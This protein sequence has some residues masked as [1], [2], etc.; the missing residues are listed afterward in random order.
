MLLAAIGFGLRRRRRLEE[1]DDAFQREELPP[2]LEEIS[3][4]LVQTAVSEPRRVWTQLELAFEPQSLT[5]ALVNARLA[6]RLSLKNLTDAAVGPVSIACDIISAHSS[7]SVEEQL[8]P[9]RGEMLEPKHEIPSL[10]PGETV[11]LMSELQLPITAI[12]PIRSGNA[13]L[14]VPL[15]RFRI[16][17]PDSDGPP[18]VGTRIFVI[19]ERPGQVGRRLKP[20]RVDLGPRT[21]SR[22]DQREI[23]AQSEALG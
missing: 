4:P 13:S 2:D 20:I 3:S 17:A 8:L 1:A 7:L 10:V 6:Y 23:E 21:F 12:L 16:T 15:V 9:G 22:I 14:F 11:S 5:M 19:G 18:L